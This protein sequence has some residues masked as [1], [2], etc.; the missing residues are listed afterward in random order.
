MSIVSPATDVWAF[1]L[2]VYYALTGR[3]YWRAASGA[4]GT[5]VSQLLREL[6]ADPIPPASARA[7]EQGVGEAIPRGFDAWLARCL[8][9][10]PTR[11]FPDGGTAAAALAQVL[12]PG[13]LDGVSY[14]GGARYETGAPASLS[15]TSPTMA[16]TGRNPRRATSTWVPALVGIALLLLGVAASALA[17]GFVAFPLQKRVASASASAAVP[18]A[19]ASDPPPTPTPTPTPTGETSYPVVPPASAA[20]VPVSVARPDLDG[21]WTIRAARTPEGA[22]YVGVVGI[23]TLGATKL[24]QWRLPGQVIQ[25]VGRVDGDRL[26]VAYG[27]HGYALGV[28]HIQGGVLRGRLVDATAPEVEMTERLRGPASLEGTFTIEES[29]IGAVGSVIVGRHGSRMVFTRATAVSSLRGIGVRQGDRIVVAYS[30]QMEAGVVTYA[31]ARDGKSMDGVWAG[32]LSP[33]T[34]V[35]TLAR[36]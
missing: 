28:Y 23:S 36:P 26:D 1:G 7:A 25:G 10:D 19:P 6:L 29:S 33:A 21:E 14:G 18:Q 15:G 3:P 4:P 16:V 35:E 2:L 9:R 30:Q 32:G 11:R 17:L 24:V 8:E 27:L 12:G 13:N 22:S 5:N 34:G 20:P 31:L